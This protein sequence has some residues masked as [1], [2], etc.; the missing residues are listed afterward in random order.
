MKKF[1]LRVL[2]FSSLAV[3]LT[4]GLII[5]LNFLV[6]KDDF[7]KIDSD[8]KYLV[9]G[10]SHPECA[11]NDSLIDHFMNFG[12]SGESYF[13]TYLK[14]KKILEHNPTIQT[15]FVEF[16]NG[17][18]IKNIDPCIW[19]DKHIMS[20]F[21]KYV[22]GLD[23][24][25]YKVLAKNNLSG[26]LN[27]QSLT[28]LSNFSILENENRTMHHLNWGR[29]NRLT[30]NGQAK[31]LELKDLEMKIDSTLAEYATV[32][33]EYLKKLVKVCKERSVKVIFIRSPVHDKYAGRLN[34]MTFRYIQ[35]KHFS[36]IPFLDYQNMKF[37]DNEF[38]DAHH[39]NFLGAN[40]FSLFFNEELK[41]RKL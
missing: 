39:L 4:F 8:V 37:E 2:L 5:V 14:T 22:Y 24:E 21:P 18:M 9:V 27:A 19:D 3:S 25:D 35:K 16:N 32:N 41:N 15:I 40:K 7:Y 31:L 30:N 1:L 10:D 12:Q 23:F 38:A 28:I 11:L 17:Q 6:Q 20:K 29:Y 26:L 13:Y 33:I 36:K 34:E